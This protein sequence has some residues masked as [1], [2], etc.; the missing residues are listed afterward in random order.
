MSVAATVFRGAA[1]IKFQPSKPSLLGLA[2]LNLIYHITQ[3]I[4]KNRIFKPKRT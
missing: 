1:L 3:I 4:N 2:A